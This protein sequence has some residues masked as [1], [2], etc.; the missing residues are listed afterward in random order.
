MK[1]NVTFRESTQKIN[2]N[3]GETQT[4][5]GKDGLS[6][7]EIAI[8]NGFEGTEE[9][10]LNSLAGADGKDGAIKLIVVNELPTNNIDESAIYL[11]PSD[12]SAE[13]NTFDEYIYVDGTWEKIGS[14]GVAVNL[15]DYVKE[16]ITAN[17]LD[18]VLTR[19]Y[20]KSENVWSTVDA[21]NGLAL[22]ANGQLIVSGASKS[23]IDSKNT[24]KKPICP[25]NL[26]YAIKV[27]LTTNTIA[28]TDEEK[29]AAQDWLGVDDRTTTL[30]KH[31]FKCPFIGREEQGEY[32]FEVIDT[33]PTPF[34]YTFENFGGEGVA[35]RMLYALKVIFYTENFLN[36]GCALV[37][38]L[39]DTE[40][41]VIHA[42]S[43]E[44]YALDSY[45]IDT[46][47]S[48]DTIT[49]L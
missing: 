47:T 22:L 26:D 10:W 45:R 43:C 19:A 1:L 2:A 31:T 25:E 4:I 32:T 12:S 27:G 29:V 11:L 38:V 21:G 40:N 15:D 28:L 42:M 37:G 36:G 49:K 13:E 16:P 48:E 41:G 6:A 18:S 14:A 17:R 39:Y 33:D 9:E 44:D 30:Y 5:H 23:N 20:G 34:T 46:I 7:Y 35:L 8:K 3:F 24:N